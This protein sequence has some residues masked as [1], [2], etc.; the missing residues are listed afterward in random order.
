[1]DYSTYVNRYPVS[2]TLRFRLIPQGKT[3][4]NFIKRHLLE[5]DEK[6][7]DDYKIVKKLIDEYHKDF[8]ERSLKG[9]ELKNLQ[10]YASLYFRRDKSS[11]DRDHLEQLAADLRVEIAKSFSKQ[12]DFKELFGKE[13]ITDILPNSIKEEYKDAVSSFGKFTSY[14]TNFNQV[15]KNLYSSEAK[16][17]GIAYRLIDQNLPKFLDNCSVGET[18]ITS[19]EKTQLEEIALVF[20]ENYGFAITDIFDVTYYKNVLTQSGIDFYN[21]VI[22]GFSTTGNKKIKGFNEYINEYNQTHDVKLPKLKPLY[23]QLLSD[24]VSLSYLPE[25]FNNDEELA[26]VLST[27]MDAID[28]ETG[29]SLRETIAKITSMIVSVNSYNLKG[30]F[31]P[32]GH[33]VSDISKKTTGDWA[34]IQSQLVERYNSQNKIGKDEVDSEKV[35]EK[36]RKHFKSIKSYSLAN[37]Q[38]LLDESGVDCSKGIV[39]Y[40]SETVCELKENMDKTFRIMVESLNDR[41]DK[42]LSQDQVVIDRIKTFLDIAKEFQRFSGYL[43]G[44]GKEET[45]DEVFYGDYQPLYDQLASV[46]E[47]YNKV[48]NYVTKKPYSTEKIKLNFDNPQFLGGWDENKIRDYQAVLLEKEGQY[49]LGVMAKDS[50]QIFESAPKSGAADDCYRRMEYKLLPGPNKMLPKVFFSKKGLATFNPS[51]EIRTIYER[52]TFI[53]GEDFNLADCHKLIDFYKKA[54]SEHVDWCKFDF[55]FRNTCNYENIGQFY[56][57]VKDQGYK[58]SFIDVPSEYV[59][60]MVEDGKL[61]LFQI[62]NKD[63]SK[64]S[65]GT[66]NLHTLYFKTLFSEANLKDTIFALNGEAEMFYRKASIKSRDTVVH[67]ANKPIKNKNPLNSKGES[68][69]EYDIVKDKRYCNSQFFFHVPIS[70]NFKADGMSNINLDVRKSI[71]DTDEQFIIGIDRGERNLLYVCVINEEGELVEQQSLNVI[72]NGNANKRNAVNYHALLS[73]KEKARIVARQDWHSIESIKEIKEGYLSQAIHVITDLALKYQAII[74]LEDLNTGFKNSRAKVEK[75]VYQKFEK[76]LIDKLNYYADKRTSFSEEGSILH[77]YQLTEKFDSFKTM[78][79]QN[80]I[81]F[82]VPAWLTSKIDPTTG[83]VDLIK[84]KYR[85]VDQARQFFSLF[86]EI[87]Y[88]N[89]KGWFVFGVDYDKFPSAAACF[90]KKWTLVTKGKRVCTFRDSNNNGEWTSK[91]ID[92]TEEFKKLFNKYGLEWDRVDLQQAILEQKDKEFFSSLIK[93]VSLML[94]MRNSVTGTEIDY[95]QSPVLNTNQRCFNSEDR[96][97]GLPVDA[98]A[99]GAY[100]I[101]L[102]ALWIVKQIRLSED[103]LKK[104][105]LAI[106][107]SDWL[108]FVQTLHS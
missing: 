33:T 97:E 25:S 38:E 92:L 65:K 20:A 108:R 40:L 59:E 44:S 50:R 94:Q 98:D 75:Q 91:E 61:F 31:V 84:P 88:D 86:D 85:S 64:Y 69:F 13:I 58:I 90:K 63:F 104:I 73:E 48:R 79:K 27:F 96:I 28:A 67:P 93:L 34:T 100:H 49:Y 76:M 56:K 5:A 12:V 8:I 3:E 89:D 95:L 11:E 18:I 47:L 78:G 72:I 74:A 26:E 22:G 57:D 66:P 36:R 17:S 80:G 1:M 99:N 82:Y 24:K 81:L 43:L 30:I 103:D 70:L 19:L 35:V 42:K 23:K 53:K 51:E 32:S 21:T 52:K 14:F 10:E 106:S 71:R 62:Y 2:K 107:N 83:F 60:K 87:K 37:L 7:A 41:A 46:N 29:L 9:V 105:K 6:R 15:R 102:K 77:G 101:A 55:T 45:K 16:S 54:I 39:T 4:E 68:V